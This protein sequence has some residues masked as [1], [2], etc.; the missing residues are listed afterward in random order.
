MIQHFGDGERL[1]GVTLAAEGVHDAGAVMDQRR[2]VL[3]VFLFQ[4]LFGQHRDLEFRPIVFAFFVF[5]HIGGEIKLGRPHKSDLPSWLM[6]GSVDGED[7]PFYQALDFRPRQF[8]A[9]DVFFD[10]SR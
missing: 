4:W 1:D 10:M 3:H 9:Q 8:P 5:W 2:Q 7:V 6:F